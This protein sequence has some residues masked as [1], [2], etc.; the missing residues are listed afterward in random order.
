LNRV[1][2]V[3]LVM[4]GGANAAPSA[5]TPAAA[6]LESRLARATAAN[7]ANPD[8][9]DTYAALADVQREMGRK[10]DAA[11]TVQWMLNLRPADVRGLWRAALLREDAG[12]LD[13]AAELMTDCYWRISE[14][15]KRAEMLGAL[16]RVYER[17][18]K[19]DEARRLR[20]KEKEL[21]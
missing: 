6:A 13:G 10:K 12:D 19:T 15:G 16:A 20:E 3:L 1:A 11:A 5:D 9:L 17:M 8:D 21:R 4:V 2:L 7:R 14:R 18:G